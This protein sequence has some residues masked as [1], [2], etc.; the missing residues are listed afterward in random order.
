MPSSF[1]TFS[2]GDVIHASHVAELHEPIHRLESGAA[3]YGGLTS[4]SSTAYTA[5]L[6]PDSN[7]PYNGG[8]M[9]NVKIHADNA[10]GSP[11]VTLNINDH[12]AKPIRKSGGESL[13]VGDLKEGQIVSLVYDAADSGQFQ[14]VG[15]GGAGSGGGGGEVPDGLVV[16]AA[17]PREAG[18][19]TLVEEAAAAG[20]LSFF[21]NHGG[22]AT[23]RF[24]PAGVTLEAGSS[25]YVASSSPDNDKIGFAL[26]AEQLTMVVGSAAEREIGWGGF[27]FAFSELPGTVVVVHLGDA[28]W[29]FSKTDDGGTLDAGSGSIAAVTGPGTPPQGSGSF[30]L[31]VPTGSD[32]A[33]LST[34]LFDGMP[35][36]DIAHFSYSTYASDVGATDQLPYLTMWVD[37]FGP[38]GGEPGLARFEFEPYYSTIAADEGGSQANIAM[39]TWQTWDVANG[40]FYDAGYGPGGG[41]FSLSSILGD[42]PEATI[43]GMRAGGSIRFASGYASG[44]DS[45]D[46]NIDGLRINNTTYDF[47]PEAE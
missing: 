42:F 5:T 19:I 13:A 23:L 18:S 46:V 26:V 24:T 45:F 11:D 9:V 29:T 32:G 2:D 1:N 8:M 37:C 31:L 27:V 44:T 35:L 21:D 47:E 10:A 4:G 20:R 39:D 33:R 25:E 34:D 38:E 7:S 6:T 16:V 15:S 22:Y 14:L 41:F 43:S 36:S 3:F 40:L 30:N 28:H 17:A 12:G